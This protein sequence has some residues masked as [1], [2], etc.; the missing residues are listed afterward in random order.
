[1]RILHVATLT[2]VCQMPIAVGAPQAGAS[3]PQ[4]SQPLAPRPVLKLIVDHPALAPYLH[5]ELAGRV[6]LVVSDHLLEPGV[7]PSKFGQPLRIVHDAEVGTQPHLRIL[8][9]EVDGSRARAV[10]EYRVE[11]VRAV[12]DLRRDSKGWWRV[13]DAKVTEHQS[14]SAF[15]AVQSRGE[16]VMGVDQYTSTH[17]FED[18]PDGGRIILDRDPH[19]DTG[20]VARIRQ[21]M[22]DIAAAFE[23]GDFTKPFRVHAEAVPGTSVMVARRS[24]I[25]YLE[26]DRPRGA[27]VRIRTTDPA[28]VA[29]VHE[30][31]A[32][33]RGA[34]HAPGRGG[35]KGHIP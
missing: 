21:H 22:R 32:F 23:A 3:G 8:S 35:E 20:G 5:P 29:A 33:Q 31:L 4:Q 30:F 9:F 10:V 25:R 6:P 34:H 13:V 16:T 26:V 27:E 2:V 19:A 1:M 28:A 11:G 7:T 17:V 18:R 12:F 15:A 14:D 24:A